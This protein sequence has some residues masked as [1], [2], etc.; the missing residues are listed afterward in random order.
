MTGGKELVREREAVRCGWQDPPQPIGPASGGHMERT[1]IHYMH[2]A[3]L[4]KIRWAAGTADGLTVIAVYAGLDSRGRAAAV[5]E[6][7]GLGL[8][9]A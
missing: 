7:Q 8:A 4:A 2:T 1:V 5:L 3:E 9:A 6:A